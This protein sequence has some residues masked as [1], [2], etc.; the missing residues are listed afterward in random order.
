MF[1]R[2]DTCCDGD[3]SRCAASKCTTNGS[4]T[5][6]A[7]PGQVAG[8]GV[9]VAAD[10]DPEAPPELPIEPPPVPVPVSMP[11]ALS[12]DDP[13]CS[14]AAVITPGWSPEPPGVMPACAALGRKMPPGP[15]PKASTATAVVISATA[16]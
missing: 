6:V 9:L 13:P 16:M 15:A 3:R 4:S 7:R 10:T 1:D 11:S 8:A 5:A 14:T 12:P 2:S